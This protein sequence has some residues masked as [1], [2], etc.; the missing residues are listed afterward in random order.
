[1]EPGMGERANEGMSVWELTLSLRHASSVDCL[2]L[3]LTMMTLPKY[4][5]EGERG[6]EGAREEIDTG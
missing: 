4:W 5:G 6:R 2:P 3:T 1:M